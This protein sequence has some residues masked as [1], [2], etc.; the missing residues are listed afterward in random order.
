MLKNALSA[1]EIREKLT[2]K[3]LGQEILLY[4]VTDSTN[5]QL[6]QAAEKGAPTGLCIIAKEQTAGRGRLGRSFLS[7]PKN[8][9]YMSV[10]LRPEIKLEQAALI[11]PAVAVCVAQAI[12]AI[13]EC[14]VTIKWVNDLF[15]REKK[16]CGILTET[17]LRP[18]DQQL[19][20]LVIGIGINLSDEGIPEAIKEIAGGILPTGETPPD[21]NQLIAEILNRM[22]DVL[23]PLQP[24]HFLPEYRSRSNLI[25]CPVTVFQNDI[26]QESGVAIDIDDSARLVLRLDSGEIKHLGSGEVSCRK[27]E[28][29][30]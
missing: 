5:L 8:G 14:Q 21:R 18:A 11:T 16:V 23:L 4:P 2:T 22:E 24:D 7:P 13:A 10:L 19:A 27:T 25:G 17:V 29:R 26:P 1:R 20:Y 6:R 30:D 3:V 12:E 28:K 15:V 9:I